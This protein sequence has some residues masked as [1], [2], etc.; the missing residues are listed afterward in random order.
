[1]RKKINQELDELLESYPA[2]YGVAFLHLFTFL[3]KV[4]CFGYDLFLGI[5][6]RLY[7]YKIFSKSD[8]K[9][10]V[11]S[12]TD[13]N[14]DTN[15]DTDTNKIKIKNTMTDEDLDN[16]IKSAFSE[17]M[18]KENMEKAKTNDNKNDN[19]KID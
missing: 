8:K 19:T 9:Y 13:T 18:E 7:T 10:D 14:T 15:T 2:Y 6:K 12:T 11:P 16:I 17:M 1:M 5:G 4:I 3:W